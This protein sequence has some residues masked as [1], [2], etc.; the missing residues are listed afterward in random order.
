MD[1]KSRLI[2]E[3]ELVRFIVDFDSSVSWWKTIHRYTHILFLSLHQCEFA[4]VTFG[5]FW[6][7][8][9]GHITLTH[10][11]KQWCPNTLRR[12]DTEE[13]TGKQWQR[14]KH[15]SLSREILCSDERTQNSDR[16]TNGEIWEGK[17]YAVK[18]NGIQR[19]RD[20]QSNVLVTGSWVSSRKQDGWVIVSAGR[21]HTR[22]G[23][24]PPNT[25]PRDDCCVTS[26]S[27]AWCMCLWISAIWDGLNCP[28][29]TDSGLYPTTSSKLHCALLHKEEAV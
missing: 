16:E 26:F 23:E 2:T 4:K 29:L 22:E 27:F 13:E 18:G 19:D 7:T 14:N 3:P 11:Q 25:V 5:Y 10:Q 1:Q 15:S 8:Q 21:A 20:I 17:K 9:F 6:E 28:V 24:R 12:K